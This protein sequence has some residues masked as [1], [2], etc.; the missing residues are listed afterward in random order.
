MTQNPA[1]PESSLLAAEL[2]QPVPNDAAVLAG[3]IR[4]IHGAAV[5]GIV[6]YGS[7]LRDGVTV[8][9]MLDFYVLT[10]TYRSFHRSA[11]WAWLNQLLPPNV[12]RIALQHEGRTLQAKYAVVSLHDLDRWTAGHAMQ[13]YLWG[14]FSQPCA[15]VYARDDGV[16]NHVRAALGQSVERMVA[17]T[18][19]LLRSPFDA[20]GLWTRGFQESYRTELRAERANRAATIYANA[21]ERYDRLLA[22]LAETGRYNLTRQD[23]EA[24]YSTVGGGPARARAW[25][26]WRV[27]R[28]IGRSFHILRLIKAA[29]TFAG[30]LDYLLWKIE[31]HSGTRLEPTTWQRRHPILAAPFLAWQLFRKGAVR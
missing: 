8:G 2:D 15:L 12:Y 9:R 28:I 1:S 20:A 17:A 6:F 5:A 7:C 14:R 23:G 18:L 11:I 21:P 29:F 10:D 26:T 31:Q 27:R 4:D 19:P 30:G 25:L 13:P 24:R 3:R 22:D 16:H